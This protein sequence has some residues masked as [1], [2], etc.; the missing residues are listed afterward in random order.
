MTYQVGWRA[1]TASGSMV[2]S[3]ETL[4]VTKM[5]E[6][7]EKYSEKIKCHLARNAKPDAHW[8][9]VQSITNTTFELHLPSRLD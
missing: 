1:A 4:S 9:V 7:A 3:S 5:E 2:R 6:G 8:L